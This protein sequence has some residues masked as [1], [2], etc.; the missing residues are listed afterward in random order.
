MIVTRYICDRCGKEITGGPRK[1]RVIDE[2]YKCINIPEFDSADFCENCIKDMV[3]LMT[4]KPAS[5]PEPEPVMIQLDVQTDTGS[6]VQESRKKVLYLNKHM[7]EE[8]IRRYTAGETEEEIADAMDIYP[9]LVRKETKAIRKKTE[10]VITELTPEHEEEI[11]RRY[12]NGEEM[13]AIADDMNC[14]LVV[15]S[16]FVDKQDLGKERYGQKKV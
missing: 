16:K 10:P 9:Y 2:N 5:D 3:I 7:R 6:D 12:R 14:D 8:V 4:G 15:V 1:L 13:E 11:T